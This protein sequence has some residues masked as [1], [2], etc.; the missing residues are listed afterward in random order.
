MHFATAKEMAKLDKLATRSG[1]E[2]PQMMELAGWRMVSLFTHLRILKNTKVLIICGK[3]NKGGDGLSAARHLHNHGFTVSVVL[4][5]SVLSQAAS[6]QLRI[7]KKMRIP[8]ILYPS[9]KSRSISIIDKSDLIIDA[10]IGYNLEGTP[11]GVFREIIELINQAGK[12]VV[13]YD[14]PSGIDA[15]TGEC[16]TPCIQA[17][18]TMTLALPKKAFLHKKVLRKSGQV[19][20]ADIGIPSFLYKMVKRYSRPDFRN[21]LIKL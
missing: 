10:L 20:L 13:A 3:G 8:V 21:S 4:V 18:A 17:A 19:F 12:K 15:T 5:S 9:Q 1:L 14:I 7:V 6:H 16:F 2:I 11:R